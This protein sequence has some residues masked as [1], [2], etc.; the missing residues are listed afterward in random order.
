M[1]IAQSLKKMPPQA[2]RQTAVDFRMGAI[3]YR[4]IDKLLRRKETVWP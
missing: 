3:T 2:E 1:S 4:R